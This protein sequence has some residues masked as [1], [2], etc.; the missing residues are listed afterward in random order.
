ML[1]ETVDRHRGDSVQRYT[2]RS[3]LLRL[4]THEA[5]HVGEIATIQAI[6]GRPEID[7]WPQGYHSV[8]GPGLLP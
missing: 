4:I 5:Y 7:L 2:R 8:E 1:A 6:H 3:L